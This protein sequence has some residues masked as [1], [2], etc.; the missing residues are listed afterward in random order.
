ESA[1]RLQAWLR[2]APVGSRAGRVVLLG[3]FNAYA[4]EDPLHWLRSEGGWVDAFA[5]AKVE[6][7]WSY[8]YDGLSGRLDHAL[9]SPAL[10]PALRG[11]AEWDVNADERD[12]AG[13]AGRNEPGPGRSSDHDPLLLG[14]DL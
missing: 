1:R 4:M 2:T 12:D 13:Y 8:V 3:D 10:V 6:R 11:A 9:L 7:P 14:L 5:A